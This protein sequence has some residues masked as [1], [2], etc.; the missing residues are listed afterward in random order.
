VSLED[1]LKAFKERNAGVLTGGGTEKKQDKGF[2][3]NLGNLAE[4]AN[5]VSLV[6]GLSKLGWELGSDAMSMAQLPSGVLDA[7]LERAGAPQWLRSGAALTNPVNYP[8]MIRDEI[9]GENALD[10]F[11]AL[12]RPRD[13]VLV[14]DRGEEVGR[15][16]GPKDFRGK[17]GNAIGDVMPTYSEVAIEGPA[18]TV[19]NVAK[20]VVGTVTGN[21]GDTPY[22]KAYREGE[23]PSVL[24]GDI[25]NI[26]MGGELLGGVTSRAA[27]AATRAEG[28][29]KAASPIER[30]AAEA[31]AAPSRVQE[32]L[33]PRA[34][35][36][37]A[38][39]ERLGG[40]TA[41][42]NR[43]AGAPISAPARAV[44]GVLAP[45]AG[46]EGYA[47]SNILPTS[48]GFAGAVDAVQTGIRDYTA[49]RA[50]Q[51]AMQSDAVSMGRADDAQII[52][53]FQETADTL[54]PAEHQAIYVARTGLGEQAWL[55]L[56]RA[57]RTG[58]DAGQQSLLGDATITGQTREVMDVLHAWDEAKRAATPTPEQTALLDRL[59]KASD[60]LTGVQDI[61]N[62][63]RLNNEG[64]RT[65]LPAD[66]TRPQ[67]VFGD[68]P[69]EPFVQN[70]LARDPEYASAQRE[71]G[72]AQPAQTS[73][74]DDV[75]RPTPDAAAAEARLAEKERLAR[76]NPR[77]YPTE[78]K[79]A[80]QMR[81]EGATKATQLADELDA[82]GLTD[83]AAEI[84][85]AAEAMP[86]TI[87]DMLEAGW[88]RPEHVRAGRFDGEGL[89][90]SGPKGRPRLRK[91]I[92]ER[93]RKGTDVDFD[94]KVQTRRLIADLHRQNLN[95]AVRQGLE[96]VAEERPAVLDDILAETD[97]PRAVAAEMRRAGYEPIDRRTLD[98]QKADAVD[99]QGDG[100]VW[101]PKAT[102]DGMEAAF[103]VVD[104]SESK[105]L[106]AYDKGMSLWKAGV[107]PLNPRWLVGNV[108]GNTL[109]AAAT[110]GVRDV[111]NP[112]L[113]SETRAALR[114]PD[115]RTLG[116][117][118][119]GAS[120]A[121]L[122]KLLGDESVPGEA[123]TGVKGRAGKTVGGI[124][125]GSYRAN[126]KID[127]FTHVL[128]Y[129]AK[130]NE[131]KRYLADLDGMLAKG[132]ITPERHAALSKPP[133]KIRSGGPKAWTDEQAAAEALKYA[134]DFV[135]MSKVERNVVRRAMP[136]YAWAR[137]ITQL[138]G[139]L[140]LENPYRVAWTMKITDMF[141]DD[142]EL[143]D[144]LRG[145]IPL[146]DESFLRIPGN[147]YGG[148][149][150]DENPFF[151]PAQMLSSLTPAVQ[152]PLGAFNISGRGPV[153]PSMDKPG[154]IGADSLQG[155]LTNQ[156]PLIR[157]A[158]DTVQGPEARY[159]DRTP[160]TS[161]GRSVENDLLGGRWAAP[162]QYFTGM[163]V[164]QP[165]LAEEARKKLKKDRE[166]QRQAR[167]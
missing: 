91:G 5:P 120:E 3:D 39:D 145:A 11:K 155:Y 75:T 117:L 7:G 143:P 101:V 144:W 112:N 57:V 114:N 106:Q 2:F 29:V 62:V 126:Q 72:T 63:R 110:L 16:V 158:A 163:S 67:Q 38:A 122:G 131:A 76:E 128:I 81:D 132:E 65:L 71:A 134:G 85:R 68:E 19:G 151:N 77:N 95:I 37:R 59:G 83:E 94:P 164:A 136:F 40:G 73:L 152:V 166:A 43:I 66:N 150:G 96:R 84:R 125:R 10:E 157:T 53:N 78:W 162:V 141:S 18:R 116:L 24:I 42:A 31:A 165:D 89:L 142:D 28:A 79:L 60:D 1:Q 13:T 20:T 104:G 26:A 86:S 109:L 17:V 148:V 159:M 161:R 61:A 50:A 48:Q 44:R 160:V 23:L 135:N 137:H 36:L 121:E 167:R 156:I 58:Q 82:A 90:P 41:L 98:R 33:A 35:M 49:A 47:L 154:F 97:S 88:Q 64:E 149:A 103:N 105:A 74:F 127:D 14:N 15:L 52:R 153:N 111:L 70:Q 138:V 55:D 22:A 139:R 124:L 45:I 118:G 46:R 27:R 4:M 69:I 108:V 34:P 113:W 130:K 25:G 9:Q 54:T 146:G 92:F 80:K 119:R 115:D 100:T 129:T 30:A 32:I 102:V 56:D 123:V 87:D 6:G 8:G 147:P 133:E 140:P 51:G 99:V 12:A 93:E 107:L 21:P